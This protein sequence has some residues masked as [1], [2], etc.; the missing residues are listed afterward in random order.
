MNIYYRILRVY[1]TGTVYYELVVPF[2]V[3][4][5][6]V[7]FAT[8]NLPHKRLAKYRPLSYFMIFPGDALG[9]I[10]SPMRNLVKEQELD[11][12]VEIEKPN[13]EALKLLIE[14][15]GKGISGIRLGR[16]IRPEDIVNE[17]L[18]TYE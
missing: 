7:F 11:Y 4:N 5:I 10:V 13:R 16:D 12:C 14:K 1:Y 9:V 18:E 15:V 3:Y 17:F 8:S 6:T 2:K